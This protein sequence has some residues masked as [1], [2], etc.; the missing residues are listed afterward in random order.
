MKG[1]AGVAITLGLLPLRFGEL[2][3]EHSGGIK[4]AEP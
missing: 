3:E 4:A 2:V 1:R